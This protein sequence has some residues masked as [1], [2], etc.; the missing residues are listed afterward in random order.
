MRPRTK[1]AWAGPALAIALS[2][3]VSAAEPKPVNVSECVRYSQKQHDGGMDFML[4]STCAVHLECSISWVLRC[5]GDA[6]D[7]KRHEASVFVLPAGQAGAAHGSADACG[8]KGWSISR[9]RWT[10]RSSE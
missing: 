1:A 2:A 8:E 3:A 4:K 5:D 10:C 7:Q 6:A 9:V